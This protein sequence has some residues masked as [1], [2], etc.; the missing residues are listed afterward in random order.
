MLANAPSARCPT[1]PTPLAFGSPGT[2]LALPFAAT[3]PATPQ[4]AQPTPLTAKMARRE[5][6]MRLVATGRDSR[7]PDAPPPRAR[8]AVLLSANL[9]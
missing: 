5:R 7:M 3:P 6:L 4:S 1:P 8:I 9:S 2:P